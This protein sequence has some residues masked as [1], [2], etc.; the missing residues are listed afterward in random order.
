METAGKTIDETL[1]SAFKD[2]LED[3]QPGEKLFLLDVFATHL[4]MYKNLGLGIAGAFMCCLENDMNHA[5]YARDQIEE[6]R[7][8]W[9]RFHKAENLETE[10]LAFLN[11]AT[12]QQKVTLRQFIGVNEHHMQRHVAALLTAITNYRGSISAAEEFV[13]D[14]CKDYGDGDDTPYPLTP[15]SAREN[16]KQFEINFTDQIEQAR[17]TLKRY[18]DQTGT[19]RGTEANSEEGS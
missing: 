9:Q 5:V 15:K 6:S 18:P 8:F 13:L 10:L 19:L 16:L 17:M 7:K 2:F 11:T 3:A 12:D 14:T 4:S 1:T